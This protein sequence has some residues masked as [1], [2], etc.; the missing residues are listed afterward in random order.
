MQT[1]P[2]LLIKHTHQ[3]KSPFPCCLHV[4]ELVVVVAPF[5]SYYNEIK[6]FPLDGLDLDLWTHEQAF[7]I[8]FSISA[9]P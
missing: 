4:H 7:Y 5:F 2:I 8:Y 6:R 1:N 9:T 3:V